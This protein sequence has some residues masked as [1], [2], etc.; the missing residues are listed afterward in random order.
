[1]QLGDN[2]KA[3][4][5]LKKALK[6]DPDFAQAQATMSSLFIAMGDYEE[7]DKLLKK[8]LDKENH[9]GPAWNNKAIVDAHFENWADADPNV[10]S[11]RRNPALRCLKSSRRKCWKII[12][13]NNSYMPAS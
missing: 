7:A 8:I 13:R 2:D 1:M 11:R 6:L 12:N 3:H 9:F 4:K 5:A 10:S